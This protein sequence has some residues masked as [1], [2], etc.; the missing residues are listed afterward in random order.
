MNRGRCVLLR[1][2]AAEGIRLHAPVD[3]TDVHH[4]APVHAGEQ[5][6]AVPLGQLQLF[7]QMEDLLAHAFV[8]IFL[9]P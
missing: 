5:G 2:L 7:G 3:V 9:L 4:P 1:R 6:A 8:L